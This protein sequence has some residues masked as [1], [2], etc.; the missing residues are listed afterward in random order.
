MKST[1]CKSRFINTA[2]VTELAGKSYY[3]H[4][5]TKHSALTGRFGRN[6]SP[7]FLPH[8]HTGRSYFI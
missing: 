1:A 7:K 8:L 2:L 4:I 5:L 3:E 6:G